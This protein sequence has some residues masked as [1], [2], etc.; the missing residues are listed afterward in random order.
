MLNS[1]STA[2]AFLERIAG[3]PRII[4]DREGLRPYLSRFYLRGAPVMPDGS[5]PYNEHGNPRPEAVFPEGG[6]MVH[7][8]HQS[9]VGWMHNHPWEWA[10]SLVLEHGYVEHRLGKE[11]R[12]VKPGDVNV[13]THD[14]FHLVNLLRD[15]AGERQA[16]T[17]FITGPK[18]K[19]W[20][21]WDPQRGEVKPW[22]D[23]IADYRAS[24]PSADPPR[25]PNCD[26]RLDSHS[27]DGICGRCLCGSTRREM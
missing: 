4:K 17:L 21:F 15:G 12:I 9:D 8:F 16:T 13:I 20:G 19:Q 24:A 2:R 11:S 18:T 6:V 3:E 27:E 23:Y 14:D 5:S 26:H 1:L 22:R 7:R 25:C 10:V